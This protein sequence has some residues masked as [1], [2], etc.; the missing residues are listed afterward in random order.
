MRHINFTKGFFVLKLEA[1]RINR[2]FNECVVTTKGTKE[3]LL[4]SSNVNP[5]ILYPHLEE[6]VMNN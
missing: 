4:L 1:E 5:C 3:N 2:L 6:H